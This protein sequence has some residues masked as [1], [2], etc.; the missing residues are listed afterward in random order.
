MV[1][2]IKKLV[3]LPG[4]ADLSGIAFVFVFALLASLIAALPFF[5]GLRISPIIT[6]MLLGMLYA[7]YLR[8]RAPEGWSKG[9]HYSARN[10]LRLAII[11]YGFRLTFQNIADVG[12]GGVII[13]ALMV[14]LT[15]VLGY[16]FGVKVL[17]MDR[18][19]T[20]LTA[21]GA[22]ICGAAAVLATESVIKAPAHKSMVAVGTVVL[23]GTL[24]MFLYPFLYRNGLI[25]MEE[26]DMGVYI[27]AAV[28]EVAHVVAAGDAISPEAGNNAVI[29]KMIRVMML[30]PFLML[31][32]L[33]LTRAFKPSS[34]NAGG[35]EKAKIHIPWF[36]VLFIVVTGFNSLRLLPS[37]VVNAINAADGFALTMA[38][39]ALGMETSMTK[40]RAVGVKPLYLAFALFL[41]L[42]IG[43]Y[44]ITAGILAL[45]RIWS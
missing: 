21:S 38:V 45:C 28:H 35:S 20:I 2:R 1:Q 32:G 9:I 11:F 30:A 42:L 33:W 16:W 27:G 15:F 39:S 25:P 12:L 3:P 19:T 10:I 23:F 31:L 22:S 26:T 24:S 37:D 14:G 41:W 44:A 18:E 36:A 7:Q 4:R 13:S 34:E 17:R 29:V 5:T 40:I 6:G 8:P 43:G